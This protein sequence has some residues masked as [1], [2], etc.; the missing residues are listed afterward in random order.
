M[1]RK[2]EKRETR[3]IYQLLR[4]SLNALRLL[5]S[6]PCLNHCC[7]RV[8]GVHAE[9]ALASF[10]EGMCDGRDGCEGRMER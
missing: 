10:I 6:L 5:T 1:R 2:M 4:C 7:K 8:R 9:L 3:E